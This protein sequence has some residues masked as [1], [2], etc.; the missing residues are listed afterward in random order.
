MDFLL[1]IGTEEIPARFIPGALRD[2]K[3]L[4]AQRL[5]T[6]R[7]TFREIRIFGTPRRLSAVVDG[8]AEKQEDHLKELIGPPEKAVFA[9]DGTLTKAGLGFAR[10]QGVTPNDLVIIETPKGRY[11][12]IRQNQGGRAAKEILSGM[13]PD[14]VKAIPFPKSMRWGDSTLSFARPIHWMVALFGDQIIPL[15]WEGPAGGRTTYGHRFMA[16][17]PLPLKDPS[18]YLDK[19]RNAYVLAEVEE[20]KAAVL[21]GIEEAAG[22]RGALLIPDE[23]LLIE[24]THLVEYPYPLVGDF[25]PRFLSLPREVLITS[26][27]EHQRYFSLMDAGGSLIPHFIAVNNTRPLNPEVVKKGHERVLRARLSDAK[28]FY[29]EDL[30]VSLDRRVQ[31]L[32]GMTFH[33]RLGTVRDKVE[34]LKRLAGI[35]ASRFHPDLKGAAQRAAW[36]CKADLITQMV[37]EFPTLQGIMGMVYA[38]QSGEPDEVAQAI[39]EHYLP[40][41]SQGALPEGL[42]GTL[43]SLADKLDNLAG[44]FAIGLQPTG[45]ADPYA[46]RRQC[47]GI[48]SILLKKE[49][50]LPLKQAFLLAREGFQ[51]NLDLDEEALIKVLLA[52]CQ[53][54]WQTLMSGHG[55]GPEAIDAVLSLGGDDFLD[56]ARRLES[57]DKFIKNPEFVS[58]SQ[59]LKRILNILKGREGLSEPKAGYLKEP[60]EKELFEILLAA[61]R[62]LSDQLN[63]KNYDQA[64]SALIP[65]RS[66]INRFFDQVLV[67]DPD[68]L[69]RENRLALLKSIADLVHRLAYLEKIPI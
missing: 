19:L 21:T 34:R 45:T 16:P 29:E 40:L 44:F 6:E 18:E 50:S 30:K 69:I 63:G 36:L 32:S 17:D 37:G 68:P 35:L 23:A 5:S 1:E 42:I 27:R 49:I 54:R 9:P 13:I 41:A 61:T 39:R 14:L 12:G 31:D 53:G 4:L 48:L 51:V 38:R 24:V 58:L 11:V 15:D 60:G 57:L 56:G 67:M 3:A 20:R 55:F 59:A 10:G 47:L 2:L 62:F 26:M 43:V 33:R 22:G 7:L 66:P 46:L 65:L 52:F 28:F 25:E 64:F 8:L